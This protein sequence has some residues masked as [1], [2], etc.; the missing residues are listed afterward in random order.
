MK[1]NTCCNKDEPI[2]HAKWNKL[3]ANDKNCMIP[4]IQGG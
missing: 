2:K 4:L 3:E 1:S